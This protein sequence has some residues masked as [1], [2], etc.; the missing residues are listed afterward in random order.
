MNRKKNKCL[1]YQFVTTCNNCGFII[2]LNDNKT[3]HRSFCDIEYQRWWCDQCFNN[4]DFS[5]LFDKEK[6]LINEPYIRCLYCAQNF[7]LYSQERY[8]DQYKSKIYI[9]DKDICST[10]C[11]V[12]ITTYFKNNL[13]NFYIKSSK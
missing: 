12:N 3:F 8:I 4:Y 7:K 11:Y 5:F 2:N 6:D 10:R 1:N 9:K 13:K